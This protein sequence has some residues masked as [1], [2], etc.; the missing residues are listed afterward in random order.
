MAGYAAIQSPSSAHV[1]LW[2][3]RKEYKSVLFQVCGFILLMESHLHWTGVSSNS[4]KSTWT[5]LCYLSPLLGAY[6]A[7]ERWGRFKT[8]A[9]FGTWYLLGDILMAVA[10]HPHVLGWKETNVSG[11]F[12][13]EGA[14]IDAAQGLFVFAL[15]ACIGIGTGA[16]KSNVITL[17]ADQF[18]PDDPKE[19][20][21]KITFFSYFYWCVNF[22]AAFSY[23]YLATLCVEGSASISE[24]YGYFATFL[25]CAC[26]MA[27]A[28]LFFFLGSP[29][30]IKLPPNSDAMS[31]LV[32]VLVRSSA[33]SWS[34]KGACG[35]F[36]ILILS[37]V[38]NLIAVFLEDGSSERKGL[39][40]VA[41][42]LAVL[43]CVT[44]VLSGINYENVN[45]AKRSLG[46]PVDDQS[47]DEIKMVVRVLPFAS[48]M[49]MWQCVYDQIDANFQSIAQQ[50]DLRFG[51]EWDATQLSGAVLGVFDPIAIVIL[52]P[53]LD[54][55]IYPA[56][57]KYFGKAASPFGKV[58]V[59]LIIST[60]TM[61]YVGGFE[62]MRKDSGVIM[63]G[64][65]T[66]P[67]GS[68]PYVL[69]ALCECLINVTAYDVFYSEVPIYLKST[70]QAINLFMVSM[71][72]NVTSIFTLL[73]QDDIPN[74]LNDGKLENMFF[75][76]GAVSAI[77]LFFYIIVMRKMQFGMDSSRIVHEDEV[78]E[79]DALIDRSSNLM[80]ARESFTQ[81]RA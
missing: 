4:I 7:D 27:V 34:A 21:Q 80:N 67:D 68:F 32:K 25:I 18:N 57:K 38:L 74:N 36:V 24:D 60:A 11:V 22:G 52:I 56:Y 17:G 23:G 29:R 19:E 76:V 42:A 39:T 6:L 14:N 40:Y 50:T 45:A 10:A 15:F 28:L 30:Y 64:N 20:A 44:W 8:I 49:V 2:D 66:Y 37:F 48:F 58:L 16:I 77:N 62:I 63:L 41:G 54:A 35:G 71:G 70:C 69:V 13:K 43:G 3:N 65:S 81:M 46:G 9:I 1:S 33:K 75:A 51:D 5:S 72:S 31:K 59:G 55:V 61:F 78:N 53:L 26:V 79:K 47:I 12:D 73:F